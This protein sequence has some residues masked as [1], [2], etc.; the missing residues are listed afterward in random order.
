VTI[1]RVIPST[2]VTGITVELGLNASITVN[3]ALSPSS[4][5]A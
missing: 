1:A 4:V 3:A 5:F 2:R